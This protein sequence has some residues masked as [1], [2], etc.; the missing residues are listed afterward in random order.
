MRSMLSVAIRLGFLLTVLLPRAGA[1]QEVMDHVRADRWAEAQAAV[2]GHPDPV[3]RKLVAWMRLMAPGQGRVDE[4]GAFLATNP[5]W[6]MQVS[7]A[8]R[9]DEALALEP[10]NALARAE[11]KRAA[12]TLTGALLRC[13]DALAASGETAA[14]MLKTAW[15]TAAGDAAWEARF[16]ARWS[17]VLSPEDHLKRFEQLSWTDPA[18]ARRQ[19]DR[20]DKPWQA[21]AEARLALRR[22][23]PAGVAQARAVP[24]PQRED[25]AL[26]LD[27]A[28][29]L[30]RVGRDEEAV[31]L[32]KAQGNAAER[33]TPVARRAQFWDERNL[34]ARRRLRQG[35]DAGAY[36]LA[37]G[38]AQIGEPRTDA[39]FLAGFIALRRLKDAGTAAGHFRALAEASRAA[40]TQ[41]R[42]QYWL[43]R[44]AG[45]EAERRNG[46]ARAAAWSST[47]YGQLAALALDG[48][49]KAF[50]ARM[51]ATRDPQPDA[52]QALDLA[53]RELARAAALLVAWGEKRRATPFLLQ[54][55]EVSPDAPDRALAARLAAGLGL[56]ET[57]VAIARRAGRDGVM[58]PEV[59]WPTLPGVP[60]QP[61]EPAMAL[62]IIRQESNF[63]AAAVSHA[64][65]RG[66]MQLMPGTAV[67]V[68]K[69]LGMAAPPLPALT[70][71]PALNMKLGTTYLRGLLDQFD[72]NL[73]MAAAGYNAG[74]RR[75]V[76]WIDLNGDPRAPGTD[77]VDWI[78]LIPFS[79]TR[80]YVQRV[81]ENTVLYR[82]RLGGSGGHPLAPW[83]R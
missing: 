42:A 51:A 83:L 20:L 4:I 10:D 67:A 17:G 39:E 64:G 30:R 33:A 78:E 53:G 13:A 65:A 16:I 57:A 14:P 61:V 72:A 25:P 47:Y 82:A 50:A 32:W 1:A 55:Y 75:V 26:F 80:N 46:F 79:E 48:D 31:A 44:A 27:H 8:R 71:D 62:A 68:A 15:A 3:A 54:L 18:A 70:G 56:T 9:R 36:A 52:G 41:G 74:P 5:D 49:G 37:S 81:V 40:I 35:D 6:P 22:D 43:A 58:L 11:C 24:L 7:L 66:L 34:M 60:A 29:Y 21:L 69:G 77:I 28:R 38:H 76:E 59:G 12:P 23:D 19:A 2:A 45:S 73:A 63:D